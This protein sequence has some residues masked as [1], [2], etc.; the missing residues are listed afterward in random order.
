M[1]YLL[2]AIF[3]LAE[4]NVVPTQILAE[5]GKLNLLKDV[6]GH[7]E[8]TEGEPCQRKN[9]LFWFDIDS[10]RDTLKY[11]YNKTPSW[12]EGS[13]TPLGVMTALGMKLRK[14]CLLQRK[15]SS[16]GKNGLRAVVR[17]MT[18]KE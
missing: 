6:E 2:V 15:E 9:D 3:Q 10:T 12:A 7:P 5:N 1:R 18:G 4:L 8:E 14:C 17:Q 16:N 11:L 13:A